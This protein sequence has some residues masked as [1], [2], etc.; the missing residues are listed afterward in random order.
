MTASP[1]RRW[2]DLIIVA[3]QDQ[4]RHIDLLEILSKVRLRKCLDAK[5]RA[6]KTAHHTLKPKGL[7]QTLRDLRAGS[8][9][10]V[11]RQGQI[12]PELRAVRE[13]RP[14]DLIE[15]FHW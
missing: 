1:R 14:P 2:D 13:H 12:L 15:S 3:V 9:E 6:G 4:S 7:A 5:V 11:E 8:V 10:P